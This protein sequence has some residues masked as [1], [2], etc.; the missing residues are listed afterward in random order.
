MSQEPM[1]RCH[2]ANSHRR[3]SSCL[4]GS[5]QKVAG[6]P[7]EDDAWKR[8]GCGGISCSFLEPLVNE[9]ENCRHGMSKVKKC[10]T[11]DVWLDFMP[12][13][14]WVEW[15]CVSAKKN[16]GTFSVYTGVSTTNVDF[17]SQS[18]WGKGHRFI[19]DI[20]RFPF[21]QQNHLCFLLDSWRR[22]IYELYKKCYTLLF[23]L[24]QDR[25]FLV[26]SLFLL[27]TSSKDLSSTCV[28]FQKQLS[29]K[30]HV[31]LW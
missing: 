23:A 31:R 28:S 13:L 7:W 20:M 18:R 11:D 5:E 27:E 10:R 1:R 25:C 30:K 3:C 8:K 24:H 12:L 16:Q 26:T 9:W 22:D 14:E 2:P 29:E 4:K 19:D 17:G 21:P 6:N 15:V